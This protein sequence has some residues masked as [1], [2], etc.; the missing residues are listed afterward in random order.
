LLINLSVGEEFCEQ[1]WWSHEVA[2]RFS[3]QAAV[4]HAAGGTTR[5]CSFSAQETNGNV[6]NLCLRV[7]YQW[8]VLTQSMNTWT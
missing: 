3:S 4:V 7:V 2:W 1:C 6:I 8:H 5:L